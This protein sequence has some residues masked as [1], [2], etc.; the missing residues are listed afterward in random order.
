MK[1][2][3][4]FPCES[5]DLL[6]RRWACFFQMKLQLRDLLWHH[7]LDRLQLLK[8]LIRIRVHSIVSDFYFLLILGHSWYHREILNLLWWLFSLIYCSESKNS[9]W[10]ISFGRSC[11]SSR[12]SSNLITL[13]RHHTRP[14]RFPYTSHAWKRGQA[15]ITCTLLWGS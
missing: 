5:G 2:L 11:A 1:W 14:L 10:S 15:L 12:Y 3:S 9:F 4:H 7:E 6:L 8:L 13:K